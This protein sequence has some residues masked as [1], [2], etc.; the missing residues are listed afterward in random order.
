MK[1][2]VCFGTRPEAIKMAPVIYSLRKIKGATV[3][4]LNT[5]QHFELLKPVLDVFGIAPDASL[6]AMR[7]SDTLDQLTARIL[8]S[9]SNYIKDL[10]PDAVL[11]HGDTSTTFSVALAGFYLKIPVYHVEAGLRSYDVMNPFP[12]EMNRKLVSCIAE[13]NFAPTKNARNNL[14]QEGV[15]EDKIMVTGNT[16]VDALLDIKK[17][18][19]SSSHGDGEVVEVCKHSRSN[20]KKVVLVTCHRRENFDGGLQNVC[21]AL[22]MLAKTNKFVFI[23]VLHMNPVARKVALEYLTG[24]DN[25][26]LIEAVD[27]LDTVRLLSNVDFVLTDSGGLQ[28]EAPA[29]GVPVLVLR[30]RTERPE[31]IEAGVAKLVGTDQKAIFDNLIELASA[32]NSSGMMGGFVN[33]YGDGLASNRIA[34]YFS[35]ILQ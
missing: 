19:E 4:V 26:K 2:L 6:E 25:V 20:D 35:S 12:E 18:L 34:D 5:G 24:L 27:Y 17:R 33:P 8:V 29:F 31:G 15:Q 22:K 14:L 9:A 11:V 23:F 3:H 10:R 32:G 7:P 21:C 28:E 16:V 30:N 13:F 1:L